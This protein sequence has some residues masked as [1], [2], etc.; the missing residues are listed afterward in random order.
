[1][2]LKMQKKSEP[3]IKKRKRT[4]KKNTL[5]KSQADK[6]AKKA[7]KNKPK[8]KP[9]PGYIYLQDVNIGELVSTGSNCKAILVDKGDASASVIITDT[10]TED[11]GFLGHQRWALKT[12]VKIR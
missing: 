1:M 7:L 6:L 9:S 12:E 3:L 4:L 5:K 2:T 10:P 8:W 11:K